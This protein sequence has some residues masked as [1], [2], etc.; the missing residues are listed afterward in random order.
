MSW[1]T[2]GRLCRGQSAVACRQ[3]IRAVIAGTTDLSATHD[4]LHLQLG[5]KGC[6]QDCIHMFLGSLLRRLSA[7][8][9]T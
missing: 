2:A 6:D 1:V 7:A 9:A 3:L 8:S 5:G 4:R